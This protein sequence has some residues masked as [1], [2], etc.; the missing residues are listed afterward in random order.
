MTSPNPGGK[1]TPGPWRIS[2]EIYIRDASRNG[3]YIAEIDPLT[4]FEGNLAEADANARLIAAAPALLE[5]LSFLA[6]EVDGMRAFED[7]VRQVIGHT[8]WS[9]LAVRL[10]EA[11]AAILQATGGENGR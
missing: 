1:H 8:N 9:V 4:D 3:A 7:G 11:R 2:D 5:A 10:K 6:N